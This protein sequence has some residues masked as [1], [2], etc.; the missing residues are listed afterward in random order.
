MSYYIKIITLKLFTIFKLQVSVTI[1]QISSDFST[2]KVL[3]YTV[4]VVWV[5]EPCRYF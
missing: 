5:Q 3:R 2:I 4:I 1:R